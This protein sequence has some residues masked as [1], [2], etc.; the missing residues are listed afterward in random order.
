MKL[1]VLVLQV[2]L[3]IQSL[4]RLIECLW[5]SIFSNGLINVVQYAF[6]LSYYILL[7]LTVL[8]VNVSLPRE[9]EYEFKKKKCQSTLF[10]QEI[11]LKTHHPHFL[12]SHL[13]LTSPFSSWTPQ[14]RDAA[15]F[16]LHSWH[17]SSDQR[18]LLQ[19]INNPFLTSVW[20]LP[21][22]SCTSSLKVD[23]HVFEPGTFNSLLML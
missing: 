11:I 21:L 10:P 2:L 1:P 9:G 20:L 4:R 19:N 5:L 15:T 6:G 16:V 18:T 17:G 8:S 12:W 23:L 14:T 3:W 13:F 22:W 7:G